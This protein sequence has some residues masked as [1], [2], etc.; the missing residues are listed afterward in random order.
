MMNNRGFSLVETLIAIGLLGIVTGA[1]AMIIAESSKSLKGLEKQISDATESEIA[2][3]VLM[4]DLKGSEPSFNNVI[5]IDDAGKNFFDYVSDAIDKTTITNSAR[6]YTMDISKKSTFTMATIDESPGGAIFYEPVMAYSVGEEPLQFDQAAQLTFVSLNKDNY[7]ALQNPAYWSTGRIL[8][9]DTPTAVRN[10]KNGVPDYASTPRS[11]SFVGVV[12]GGT[13]PLK[14]LVSML[15]GLFNTTHP[16]YPAKDINSED[17]FLRSVPPA[18]GGAAIVR[19]RPLRLIQYRLEAG[20]V[21][22]TNTLIRR[23]WDGQNNNWASDQTLA[24]NITT[25]VFSR[26]ATND[27]IVYFQLNRPEK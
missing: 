1:T 9:L 19:L 10:L 18:G 4:R 8:M 6:E 12:Q 16:L 13:S 20:K 26:K 14:S 21:A 7:L 25:A 27:P 5:M 17:V 11:P 3:R 23:M 24:T 2:E 22:G 15:P